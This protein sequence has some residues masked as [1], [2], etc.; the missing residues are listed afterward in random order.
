MNTTDMYSAVNL[1]LASEVGTISILYSPNRN[2][3]VRQRLA[4][5]AASRISY[6]VTVQIL[7]VAIY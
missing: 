1:C 5:L 6:V 2:H 7:Y 3:D 4:F